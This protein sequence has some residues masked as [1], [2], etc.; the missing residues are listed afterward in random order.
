M[1]QQLVQQRRKLTDRK[2]LGGRN[3]G[4]FDGIRN[5]HAHRSVRQLDTRCGHAHGIRVD[6]MVHDTV[7]HEVPHRIGGVSDD[8]ADG[9]VSQCTELLT[10]QVLGQAHAGIGFGHDD[11][12]VILMMDMQ[13]RCATV[14][15]RRR[16]HR[17]GGIGLPDGRCVQDDEQLAF[18]VKDL[19]GGLPDLQP[20]FLA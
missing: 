12:R 19:I 1:G 9:V 8:G 2:F 4:G 7:V 11:Q 20:L 15:V 13:D 16:K 6:R 18:L 14:L 10:A 17:C 3:V 5:H